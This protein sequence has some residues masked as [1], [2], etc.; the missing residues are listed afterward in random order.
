MIEMRLSV[1]PD[2]AF[3]A[4]AHDQLGGPYQVPAELVRMVIAFGA[5]RVDVRCRR[6]RV[7]VEGRGAVVPVAAFEALRGACGQGGGVARVQAL[8]A[9]EDIGVSA[10]GWA[11]GL[12]SR[13]LMIRTSV[14]GRLTTVT[15]RRS[16]PL[17]FSC[18]DGGA[19]DGFFIDM[20]RPDIKAQQAVSWLEIACRFSAVPVFVNGRDCRRELTSGCFRAR[21]A[22]PLPATVALGVE[23]NDP[24]VWLLR[25]GVVASRI[26]IPGWPPF[27]AA[28]EL[29][30]LLAGATSAAQHRH[31]VTPHLQSLISRVVDLTLSTVPRMPQLS[32]K[33]RQRITRFLLHAA[34][35]GLRPEKIRQAPFF[36]VVDADGVRWVSLEA[37]EQWRGEL[38]GVVSDPALVGDF[39]GPCFCLSHGEREKVAGLIGRSLPGAIIRRPTVGSSIKRSVGIALEFTRKILGPRPLRET[40][41]AE[42]ER[43]LIRALK[44]ALRAGARPIEIGICAGRHAPRRW[45]EKL[46]LARDHP[47]TRRAIQAVSA[48]PARVYVVAVAFK[49]P[50]WTVVT[51]TRFDWLLGESEEMM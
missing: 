44:G 10:L 21:I 33:Q 6:G 43:E 26:G 51:E 2:A 9:L 34:E 27:E 18:S 7:V 24:R 8:A 35:K 23:L 36:E 12:N 39:A 48:D 31:A 20:S 25:N 1:D 16:Q 32:F 17:D 50:R 46:L 40:R 13:H 15:V 14:G 19:E 45:A 4:V 29:E 5:S 42:G 37:L 3:D 11:V 47:D 38:P 22:S 30:G 49:L 28:V 41:L